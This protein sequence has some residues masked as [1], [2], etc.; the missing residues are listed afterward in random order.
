METRVKKNY[1]VVA[2]ITQEDKQAFVALA[3]YEDLSSSAILRRL[4]KDVLRGN[5]SMDEVLKKTNGEVSGGRMEIRT[6]LTEK[7]KLEFFS[8]A[9]EWDY[10][11][12]TLARLLVGFYIQANQ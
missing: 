11:P 4:I 12:G 2:H 10:L 1:S 9:E 7:D 5:L 3:A 6:R 8:V